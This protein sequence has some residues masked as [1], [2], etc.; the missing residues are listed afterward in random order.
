MRCC[1]SSFLRGPDLG[2]ACGEFVGLGS[3]IGVHAFGFGYARTSS[4]DVLQCRAHGWRVGEIDRR[5]AIGKHIAKPFGG[6]GDVAHGI[7]GQHIAELS[8]SLRCC[9]TGAGLHGGDTAA[10]GRELLLHTLFNS[11]RELRAAGA[12]ADGIL[13]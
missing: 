10:R 5:C 7:V 8:D 11:A 2:L 12:V 6:T 3:S 1:C 13:N 9:L 4:C